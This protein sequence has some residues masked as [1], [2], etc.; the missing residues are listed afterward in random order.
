[1]KL[2]LHA[3]LVIIGISTASSKEIVIRSFPIISSFPNPEHLIRQ[4]FPKHEGK[5]VRIPY[6]ICGVLTGEHLLKYVGTP[7]DLSKTPK[8]KVYLP[9]GGTAEVTIIREVTSGSVSQF[10]SKIQFAGP[11][12]NTMETTITTN[13][14]EGILIRCD[15]GTESHPQLVLLQIKKES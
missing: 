8:L 13:D 9:N 15:T 11:G 12:S 14:G 5:D 10:E 3:L 2:L 4:E 6:M 1:M 7:T